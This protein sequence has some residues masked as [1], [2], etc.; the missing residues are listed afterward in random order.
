MAKALQDNTKRRTPTP[1]ARDVVLAGNFARSSAQRFLDALVINFD[2]QQNLTIFQIFSCNLQGY[3]PLSYEIG[4]IITQFVQLC[5]VCLMP[6]P[7]S[8]SR[9]DLVW[10][11]TRH[12][13][14]R[15]PRRARDTPRPC[16]ERRLRYGVNFGHAH[17]TRPGHRTC[18]PHELADH[19]ANN[20]SQP[21]QADQ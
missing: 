3:F 16:C 7:K 17:D 12:N 2:R 11:H 15:R 1:K 8:P 10:D 9:W 6:G 14:T 4:E 19:N 5:Q 21:P 18:T 13:T 20:S